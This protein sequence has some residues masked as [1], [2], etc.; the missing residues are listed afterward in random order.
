M[1]LV[2]Q[3]TPIPKACEAMNA[4]A[5][6]EPRAWAHVSPRV[7]ISEARI[8]A[9]ATALIVLHIADDEFL[10]RQPGTSIGHHLAAGL[11]PIAVALSAARGYPRLRAGL[12][13]GIALTFGILS[14]VAGMIAL[15]AGR[16]E[17]IS[18]SEW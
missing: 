5:F 12:R 18:G 13:S 1:C 7:R 8:F 10:Q 2:P 3:R 4:T 9:A 17:G 15:G 14:I 6:A 16:G 11:V